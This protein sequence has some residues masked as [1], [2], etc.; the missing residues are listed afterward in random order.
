M[1]IA[2]WNCW[3]VDFD[4]QQPNHCKGICREQFSWYHCCDMPF[5]SFK[6]RTVIHKNSLGSISMEKGAK[7]HYCMKNSM[8][9]NWSVISFCFYTQW[10]AFTQCFMS[11]FKTLLTS[12][13]A[14]LWL[15]VLD[16]LIT[17]GTKAGYMDH[18]CVLWIISEELIQAGYLSIFEVPLHI[19]RP[20][21]D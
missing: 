12:I 20:S 13:P 10:C 16:T 4:L 11:C 3:L 19:H 1:S 18:K 6:V 21:S 14:D 5:C 7:C 17:C 8:Q 15:Q 9:L 2:N